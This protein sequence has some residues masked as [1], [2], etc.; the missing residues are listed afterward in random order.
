M[1]CMT[2]PKPCTGEQAGNLY[3]W[4]G[5]LRFQN[6]TKGW[7]ARIAFRRKTKNE[8]TIFLVHIGRLFRHLL[9][10]LRY[11][12]AQNEANPWSVLSRVLLISRIIKHWCKC[13]W[14]QNLKQ[15]YQNCTMHIPHRTLYKA[16]LLLP[17][18]WRPACS[19]DILYASL[20]KANADDRRW[21]VESTTP[22][23][24]KLF[25]RQSIS[26]T[27]NVLKLRRSEE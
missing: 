8:H 18:L 14:T 4:I 5:K 3:V 11:S 25:I 24:L 16:R 7:A 20:E 6:L 2:V 15:Y 23:L 19:W 27:T 12:S 9:Y 26:R 17:F 21:A 22:M 10:T 13:E 1:G